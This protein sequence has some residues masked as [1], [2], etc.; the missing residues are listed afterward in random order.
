MHRNWLDVLIQAI[1]NCFVLIRCGELDRSD[2]FSC[3][4]RSMSYLL[5]T[6]SRKIKKLWKKNFHRQALM[7]LFRNWRHRFYWRCKGNQLKRELLSRKKKLIQDKSEDTNTKANS[8]YNSFESNEPTETGWFCCILGKKVYQCRALKVCVFEHWPLLAALSW[9]A[10]KL[11][12]QSVKT[13]GFQW[14]RSG[15]PNNDEK[16]LDRAVWNRSNNFFVTS[17][18]ESCT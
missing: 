5:L 14:N 3:K 16:N 4:S 12:N 10:K 6:F 1:H 15:R 11:N 18:Y 9:T 8:C 7:I 17:T 2:T 13:V